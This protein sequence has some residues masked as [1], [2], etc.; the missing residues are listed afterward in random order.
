MENSNKSS[1]FRA[2]IVIG[3]ALVI[4]SL[5]VSYALYSM[6]A[7]DN[8]VSVV[9]SAKQSVTSD[10]A[11]WTVSFM[12][13][14]TL[15]N[16]KDGYNQMADDLKTVKEFFIKNGFKEDD[17][18]VSTVL[19]NE[20]Y[21]SDKIDGVKKYDLVQNVSI[22]SDDVKKVDSMSKRTN[23]LVNNGVNLLPQNPQYYYSKLSDLK[24]NLLPEALKD[25]KARANA[26]VDLSGGKISKIKSASSGVVQVLSPGSQEVSDYGTYDTS[27]IDKDVMVTVRASF[28][29]K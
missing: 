11:N 5:V 21:D 10:K 6:R 13:R 23:E 15:S 26:I 14:T 7:M 19:M 24:V 9:G 2:S 20:I 28:Q 12:R 25:A 8:V 27:S 3:I 22:S 4:M 29:I 16:A 1:I 17:L 18:T